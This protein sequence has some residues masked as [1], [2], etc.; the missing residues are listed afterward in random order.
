MV[1]SPDAQATG[2]SQ[3]GLSVTEYIAIGICSILLGLIYVASVFLYL[4]LRRRRKK[5]DENKDAER[6][7]EQNIAAEEGIIKNNP[8]L[9]LGRHFNGPDNSYSD[10]GSSDNDLTP[11]IL[12]HHDESR[13]KSNVSMRLMGVTTDTVFKK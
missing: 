7:D 11:D 13:K 9:G 6:R 5:T 4:H 12:Q 8:L 3:N 2:V 1:F 10:S